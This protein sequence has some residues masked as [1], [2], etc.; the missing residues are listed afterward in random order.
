MGQVSEKKTPAVLKFLF[1]SLVSTAGSGRS[2]GD[3]PEISRRR[4]VSVLAPLALP[5]E[6]AAVMAMERL[7][8]LPIKGP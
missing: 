3:L 7:E 4:P 6:S 2:F 8:L 5:A 1:I